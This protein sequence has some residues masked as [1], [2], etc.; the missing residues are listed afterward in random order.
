MADIANVKLGP[1]DVK[2]NGVPVGH[3][4]GGVTVNYEPEYHDVTVDKYGNTVAEKVLI[5]ESLKVTV[6]LAEFTLE[7]MALAI[8]AATTEGDKLNIGKDAGLRMSE[9]A[10]QL[11]LHPQANAADDLSEDVVLHKAI[12]AEPIEF[13]HEVDGEKVA[14]VIFHA[15]IDETQEDGSRLGFIGDSS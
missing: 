5:G 9:L 4:K 3:T 14:E 2:F 11:V 10:A 13:K 6:P 8:P 7:N 1:C 15:L 12:V